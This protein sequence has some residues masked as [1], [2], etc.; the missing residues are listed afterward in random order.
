MKVRS[1]LALACLACL[2]SAGPASHAA[3]SGRD[4]RIAFT[5]TA[6]GSQAGFTFA[7]HSVRPDGGR[8]RTVVA[9]GNQAA[10]SATGGRIAYVVGGTVYV[11]KANGNTPRAIGQGT[12]PAWSPTGDKLA[13]EQGTSDE[14]D[15]STGS[16]NLAIVD[17][18]TGESVP[19]TK[20]AGSPTWSPDG[21]YIAFV[22]F[23]SSA[24]GSIAR[25]RPGGT[26]RKVIY[27][28]DPRWSAAAP[29]WSPDGDS[30]AF[31]KSSESKSSLSLIGPGGGHARTLARRP[32][33][34]PLTSVAWA[35]SGARLAFAAFR[36]TRQSVYTVSADGGPST[37]VARRAF[38]PA[39]RPLK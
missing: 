15:T 35:P 19:L 34:H 38:E 37:L 10:Y 31:V 5:K 17:V 4:G 33:K 22:D 36:E 18:K 27:R 16:P 11:A 32:A 9:E 3:F 25:I 6:H 14:D 24:F 39:W 8:E 29:D 23:R 13:V 12:N 1:T 28:A 20:R 30:L 2:A 26:G 7:I 21:R